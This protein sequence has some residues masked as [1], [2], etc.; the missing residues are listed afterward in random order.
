MHV[1]VCGGH[2]VGVIMHWVPAKTNIFERMDEAFTTK[3]DLCHSSMGRRRNAFQI[4]TE[5]TLIP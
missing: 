3:R 2:D 5:L 4:I 1:S